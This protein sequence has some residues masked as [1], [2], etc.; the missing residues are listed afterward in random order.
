LQVLAFTKTRAF[1]KIVVNEN[2]AG[3]NGFKEQED[4]QLY[5]SFQCSALLVYFIHQHFLNE[6]ATADFYL[7]QI[8]LGSLVSTFPITVFQIGSLFRRE[9]V[10]HFNLLGLP[11]LKRLWIF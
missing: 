2:N 7:F 1:L 5:F 11:L 6:L 10:G 8:F 9:L 4:V 3:I